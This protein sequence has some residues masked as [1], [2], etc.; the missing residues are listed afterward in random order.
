MSAAD[1]AYAEAKRLIAEAKATGAVTLRFD[2]AA[3]RA[4]IQLPPEIADLANLSRLDLDSTQITDLTPLAALTGLRTLYLNNTQITDFAPLAALTGLSTL[5]LDNTQ[6]TD[7]T[8]L[9]PR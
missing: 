6:I 7:L 3:T 1:D 5:S 8:P 4:L 2:V 9:L